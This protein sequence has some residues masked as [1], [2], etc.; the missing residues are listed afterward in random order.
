MSD[1]AII[2][3]ALSGFGGGY[4]VGH[5]HALVSYHKRKRD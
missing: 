1:L 5:V 2:L 4:I 3:V